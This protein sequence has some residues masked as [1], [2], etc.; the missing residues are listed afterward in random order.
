MELLPPGRRGLR[1]YSL[2]EDGQ[3]VSAPYI[4]RTRDGLI[5]RRAWVEFT[6]PGARASGE[7]YNYTTEN[8]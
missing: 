4:R 8:H 6:S 2:N 5:V 7:A 1:V 3:S